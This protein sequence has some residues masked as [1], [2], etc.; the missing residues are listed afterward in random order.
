M[1]R[2]SLLSL[3]V[4][5][6][7]SGCPFPIDDPTPEAGSWTVMVYLL[8]DNDLEPAAL[9][10]LE[11]MMAV[12]SNGKVTFLAQVDRARGESE[13]PVGGLGNWY[14][15][16]RVKVLPG[17][18]EE[19]DDLGPV[20][21][22]S[23]SALSD[24]IAWA[25]R[26]A[27]AD[28]YMLVLWDHGGAWPQYGVDYSAGKTGLTLKQMKQGMASGMQQA[29][30]SRFAL[31]GFDACLMAT[32]E[33]ALA[34]RPYADYLLASEE[35]EPGHGW[36]YRSFQVL[37]DSTG[38]SAVDLGKQLVRGYYAQ[39]QAA[40]TSDTVTLSLLDLSRIEAVRTAVDRL[41]NALSVAGMPAKAAR[42][43]GA[44]VEFAK[45]PD[46]RRSTNMVDLG[47]LADRLSADAPAAADV[48]SAL[49]PLVV[50]SVEGPVYRR[51][52]GLSIYFPP[53][54]SVYNGDYDQVDD[55]D[56][57]RAFLKAYFQAGSSGTRPTF[58]NPNHAGVLTAAS[59]SLFIRGQLAPGGADN[60]AKITATYGLVS[61]GTVILLGDNPG[62]VDGSGTVTGSWDITVMG[63]KQGT[64][65]DYAYL[66]ASRTADGGL[67]LMVPFGYRYGGVEQIVF[68]M[69]LLDSSGN[70]RSRTF[71][72]Q[73]GEA[74]GEFT[75]AA[76]STVSTLLQVMGSGGSLQWA[77]AMETALDPRQ[78]LDFLFYSLNP[79]TQVY[80]NLTV[81]DIAGNGDYV[82]AGGT[83]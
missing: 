81:Q 68:L 28:H 66:S 75:P 20:D 22:G 55:V 76:G 82:S 63:V 33:T 57:W 64:K 46:P 41:G 52:T 1:L 2:R 9:G 21:M 77:Y 44:S 19:L 58:T 12:G 59:G 73:V 40:K 51:A 37:A 25:A 47:D 18:L 65:E 16:K 13:D 74:W 45:N 42:A 34:F 8:G 15:A 80:L 39:A 23:S 83:L 3:L 26:K 6:L 36:D 49:A 29:G 56:G 62:E 27:P 72:A 54:Q 71:Y 7:F 10:D 38:V 70:E 5:S 32:Y 31:V 30:I 17:T 61:E 11:E 24:F 60:L 69:L 14:G 48:R 4:L 53:M 79:G 35:V 67:L 50:D 43:R 78:D